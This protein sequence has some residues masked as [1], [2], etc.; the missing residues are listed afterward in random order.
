M[1]EQAK[2]PSLYVTALMIKPEVP[3]TTPN[4]KLKHDK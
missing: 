3:P 1:I 4:L 2:L